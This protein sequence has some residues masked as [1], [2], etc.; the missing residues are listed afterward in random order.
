MKQTK[1]QDPQ[2]QSTADAYEECSDIINAAIEECLTVSAPDLAVRQLITTIGQKLSCGA[3]FIYERDE[4]GF[5]K[6]SYSWV[7][8]QT[9]QDHF[10]RN[11]IDGT[12]LHDFYDIQHPEAVVAIE[13]L[14]RIRGCRFMHQAL[15]QMGVTCFVSGK[16]S[17]MQKSLGYCGFDNPDPRFYEPLKKLIKQLGYFIS[18]LLHSRN[19]VNRLEKIGLVDKLTG[20]SNR[21]GLYELVH[22]LD[23]SCSVG[24]L[25]GDVNDLKLINDE[26][27]HAAGDRLL[28][29][30]ADI[31]TEVFGVQRVFRMGGDEFLA[32]NVNLS[33]I[34][35]DARVGLLKSRLAADKIYIALGSYWMPNFH[36][37]FEELIR[38][39]DQKMYEDKRFYY[40]SVVQTD[41][42]HSG[43]SP[44]YDLMLEI[45]PH[46]GDYKVLEDPMGLLDRLSLP[47]NFYEFIQQRQQNFVHPDD[48]SSYGAFWNLNDLNMRIKRHKAGKSISLEYRINENGKWRWVEDV[49]VLFENTY[50]PVIICLCR[51]IHLRKQREL[52]R[53]QNMAYGQPLN[54][55]LDRNEHFLL[56]AD[57]WMT[58]TSA[59]SIAVAAVDIN[60]FKLYNEVYGRQ[61]GNL[62][63]EKIAAVIKEYAAG[64][65]GLVGYMGGDNF[66][67]IFSFDGMSQEMFEQEFCKHIALQHFSPGFSP[68]IGV[69]VTTDKH[70]SVLALYDKA[71]VAVTSIKGNMSQKVC[72]Y[73]ASQFQRMRD[74]QIMLIEA[75]KGFKDGEFTFYLQPK[76]NLRTGKIVSVEALARWIRN[77]MVMSPGIF[78]EAMEDNGYIFAVDSYIWEHLCI[79][80][81]SLIERGIEPLP[82]SVNVSRIDFFFC[83]VANVFIELVSRYNISPHLI[84]VEISERANADDN[85]QIPA[86]VKKLHNYGF[87]VLLDNFGNSTS[88]LNMLRTMDVDILKIDKKYLDVEHTGYQ[89]YL[90]LESVISIAHM[91]DM[92]VVAEG[93]ETE[94]QANKLKELSCNLGQ[95]Y[96]FYRPM[97]QEQFEQVLVERDKIDQMN[98]DLRK[99]VG[100]LNFRQLLNERILSDNNINSIMGPVAVFE[101]VNDMVELVQMNSLFTELTGIEPNSE[102]QRNWI[103]IVPGTT[104]SQVVQFF[105][106][107][108][109]HQDMGTFKEIACVNGKGEFEKLWFKV[110]PLTF[111][112]YRHF[113][114]V[115][116][117]RNA[118]R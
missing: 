63:L 65:Q 51:S 102:E 79:W 21:H 83:D 100:Q 43:Y 46:N 58:R 4:E 17:F 86:A 18:S 27:G 80:L 12:I 107:A 44:S 103:K 53:N 64:H 68:V 9:E 97:T 40:T 20:C 78:V 48:K 24:V 32:V 118:E 74:T 105:T 55:P 75:Q 52:A 85:E 109:K 81:S 5:F 99:D 110:Y 95:G 92:F 70:K 98:W 114:M 54:M 73:D 77:D 117:H 35:W 93:V 111:K 108:D 23:S 72:F 116:V 71:L 25:Y 82:C 104:M 33:E 47:Q 42:D 15:E 3:A 67:F 94:Q 11:M 16:L 115:L 31:L 38:M 91:L 49:L 57:E 8:A 37:S 13:K 45:R 66:C 26:H 2:P 113:Y 106:L 6:L 30:V 87:K 76:V 14:D 60:F 96:Y 56:K 1:D 69:C 84:E 28:I 50:E 101:M 41:V 29:A 36:I 39:V 34:E 7:A 10:T 90:M 89:D 59:S 61:G 88:S 22:N 112:E 19:L 62:F